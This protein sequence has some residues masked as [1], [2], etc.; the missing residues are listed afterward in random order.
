MLSNGGR[1][2]PFMKLPKELRL[3]MY[4]HLEIRGEK[5]MINLG[6][7]ARRHGP[8]AIIYKETAPVT[9]LATCQQIQQEVCSANAFSKPRLSVLPNPGSRKSHLLVSL[10]NPASS[11]ELYT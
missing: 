6:N 9:I 10:L 3:M 11:D 8:D 5:F 1:P 2:F 7:A 4:E